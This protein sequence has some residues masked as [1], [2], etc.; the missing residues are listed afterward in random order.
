MT[1][2]SRV[3]LFQLIIAASVLMMAAVIYGAMRST[4]YY[5]KRVQLANHQLE[6]IT[7]LKVNANRFSEQIAELLLIG[8]A[9]RPDFESARSELE[10]G[11]DRLE[12]MIKGELDFLSGA[13]EQKQ[14]LDELYRLER[15]RLLYGEISRFVVQMIELQN[16]GRQNDA[17]SMFRR[18]IENRLDAEFETLLTAAILDEKDE[19]EWVERRAEA[20][21]RR[22]ALM[23]AGAAA[24][25]IAFCLVSGLLLTRA[26]IQPV[27]LLTQGTE[28]VSRGELDHRIAFDSRDELGILARRFNAM[29]ALLEEQSA[30]VLR[31]RSDLEQ[32]V[33]ERTKE[34]AAANKRL[35]DLDRLRV[36]FLADISHELR[37]PLT[38]LRGEAEVTLRHHPRDAAVYRD[39]LGRIVAHTAEMSRHIEDLLFL[40]R[41]EVDTVRFERRHV[42]LQGLIAEAVRDGEAL[43]RDKNITI[44]AECPSDPIWIEADAQRFRQAL[45]I[46]LD[47]AIKYSPRDRST[48]IRVSPTRTFAEV[49]VRDEGMGIPAEE[50]PNVFDR[51]YRGRRSSASNQGGSGLG[52]SIAKWLVE[53][54]GGGIAVES[55]ENRFTEVKIR[56]P[57]VEAPP[58]VQDPAG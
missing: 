29:A 12:R 56:I 42:V 15:M 50:L 35:T 44:E 31:S 2:R 26:L 27:A 20:L 24:A 13:P 28:A 6:A 22:S 17:V 25:A 32:Q 10:A 52:L 48:S 39:T 3:R 9:E 7:A 55:E 11:F 41:T 19:V 16:Q 57:R 23:T 21:W 37:T 33:T 58:L 49:T 53:K 36:Q 4:D 5:L 8:E 38:A 40:A 46:L 14:E 51:F 30:I 54:H 1:I 45:V 43:A 34:L 47:N 18:E